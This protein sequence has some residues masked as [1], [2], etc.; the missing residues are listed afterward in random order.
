[1]ASFVNAH[2]KVALSEM[3]YTN[4]PADRG[5]WVDGQLIGTNYGISAP[6]LKAYLGRTPSVS[7][8]I[9][10]SPK[11]A[12]EIYK[13]EYWDK[14]DGDELKNQSV[15]LLLYD[16][17]VNQGVG[18]MRSVVKNA[19]KEQGITYRGII[20]DDINKAN[21]KKFFNSIFNQ[22]LAKYSSG[23]AD[24]RKGWIDRLNDI[25]F[26]SNTM[27]V[28]K[29]VVGVIVLSAFGYMIYSYTKKV[30]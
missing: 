17:A 27:V 30:K 7:E 22:R 9:N 25:K 6:V 2:R 12:S 23:Q 11:I 13:N 15:A 3:G 5:N 16:G 4:N 26:Q 14:V 10:L 18:Y 29:I 1:M 8:M 20:A 19:L 24:F 21:Q 28:G